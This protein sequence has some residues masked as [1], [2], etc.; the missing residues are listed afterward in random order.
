MCLAGTAETCRAH[1][2]D[3]PALSRRRFLTAG[4]ATAVVAAVPKTALASP[5]PK[6]PKGPNRVQDLSHV[7]TDHHP[8]YPG[9]PTTTRQTHVTIAENGFY[10]QV[11]S[12]WEHSG[13]HM[14]APGHFVEGN[15][16]SP[17]I[18][19]EELVVP[20]VVVDISA[21]AAVQPDTEVTVADLVAF[22]RRHGRIPRRALVCMDSGWDARY[23]SEAAYRNTDAGGVLRFPGF[24][25]DAVEWLLERRNIQGTGVDTLSTDHGPATIFLAHVFLAE[26]ERYGLEN[27]ANLSRVPPRGATAYVGLIR[28]EEGSGGPCRVIARW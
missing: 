15:K 14:D 5:P 7:F 12:F 21:R 24:S 13:T 22:E 19:P 4:A 11:W 9:S 17:D 2:H 18:D 26:A 8:L 1:R 10:G 20:L 3:G 23:G 16:L 6:L 27:L 25:P 28:W